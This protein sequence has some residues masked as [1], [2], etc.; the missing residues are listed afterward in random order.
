MKLKLID[1]GNAM[2]IDRT[3]IYYDD[4]EVQSVYYRAPEVVPFICR[5][6]LGSFRIA[7][8]LNY[9]HV[10]HRI[11]PRGASSFAP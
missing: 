11:N 7:I 3:S 10:L 9:R 4:F 8:L 1:L 2:P 6:I 5:L